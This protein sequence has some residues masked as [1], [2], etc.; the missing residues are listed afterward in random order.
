MTRAG[1]R[2]L[3]SSRPAP[4]PGSL[5]S[6]HAPQ[7]RWE[8]PQPAPGALHLRA[9]KGHPGSAPLPR[10]ARRAAAPGTAP[11]AGAWRADR[12]PSA[13]RAAN[14]GTAGARGTSP[15][16]CPA[17]FTPGAPPPGPSLHRAHPPPAYPQP[18]LPL[19]GRRRPCPTSRPCSLP[20]CARR[21]PAVPSRP[22]SAQPSFSSVAFFP[23]IFPIQRFRHL[24]APTPKSFLLSCKVCSPSWTHLILVA[25]KLANSLLDSQCTAHPSCAIY[26]TPLTCYIYHPL[27]CYIYYHPHLL[28]I[29]P[30][31]PAIYTTTLICYIW[32]PPTYVYQHTYPNQLYIPA[33]CYIHTSHHL[34]CIL[35]PHLLYIGHPATCYP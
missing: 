24:P 18:S 25:G 2:H 21:P 17:P 10:T 16:G 11:A 8:A 28:Y 31:S 15:P 30:P 23:A 35:P 4:G 14:C 33:P 13:G 19:P 26:T 1:E 5:S 12:L 34:L 7:E 29:P 6:S 32:Q 22:P 9:P 3:P 20:G 27:T